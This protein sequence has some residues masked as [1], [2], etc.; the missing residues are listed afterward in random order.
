MKGAVL[1]KLGLKLVKWRIMRASYGL[2]ADPIF[3][4]GQHP[5]DR[6]FRDKVDGN[7]RCKGVMRWCVTKVFLH[8]L[9]ALNSH[10]RARELR[11]RELSFILS[12]RTFPR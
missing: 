2:V 11:M 5:E 10:F 4:A 7:V 12:L 8:L 1:N 6:K 3:V 9:F